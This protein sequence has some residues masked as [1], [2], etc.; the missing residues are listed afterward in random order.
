LLALLFIYL[1]DME[2]IV[3]QVVMISSAL[4]T[5]VNVALI[6]VECN[7]LPDF[8]SQTVMITTLSSAVSLAGVI[9]MARIFFPV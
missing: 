5:G 9:Y 6:A 2:G 4:P 8:S 7:N 3:A 1:F